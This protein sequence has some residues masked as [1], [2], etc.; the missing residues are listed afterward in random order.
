MTSVTYGRQCSQH[1][2]IIEDRL[3]TE[4]HS[5]AAQF[6]DSGDK[7]LETL[8]VWLKI[9]TKPA[10]LNQHACTVITAALYLKPFLWLNEDLYTGI[11]PE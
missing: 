3:E 7:L 1:Y 10:C 2:D 6:D 4:F 11:V 8:K 5:I 9:A